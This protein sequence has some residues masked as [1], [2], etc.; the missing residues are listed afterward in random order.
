MDISRGHIWVQQTLQREGNEK[1]RSVGSPWFGG[2][3]WNPMNSSWLSAVTVLWTAWFPCIAIFLRKHWRKR[4][5][6]LIVSAA[7]HQ[8]GLKVDL[9]AQVKLMLQ[10]LQLNHNNSNMFTAVFRDWA[11]L[12]TKPKLL[13]CYLSLPYPPSKKWMAHSKLMHWVHLFLLMCSLKM[14][15]STNVLCV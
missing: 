14:N 5:V 12:S 9:L 10:G 8:L 15:C 3:R 11:S 7:G 6:R 1:C 4:P 2:C 13:S